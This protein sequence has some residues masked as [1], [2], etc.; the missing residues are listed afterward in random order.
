V[1]LAFP[2]TQ[3]PTLTATD[4]YQALPRTTDIPQIIKILHRV[5]TEDE[6]VVCIYHGVQGAAWTA[7]YACH[8]LGLPACALGLRGDLVPITSTY[9]DARVIID[10]GVSYF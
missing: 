10:L 7:A 9:E 6:G 4:I 8:I 5:A 1:P 2:V 3:A